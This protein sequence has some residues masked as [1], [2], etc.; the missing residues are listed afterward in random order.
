MTF[1]DQVGDHNQWTEFILTDICK[2]LLYEYY[3]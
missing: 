2:F 3:I 1:V